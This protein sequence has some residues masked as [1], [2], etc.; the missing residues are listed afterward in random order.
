MIDS[1]QPEFQF[2]RKTVNIKISGPRVGRH[3]KKSIQTNN[4]A[5]QMKNPR[6]NN[7]S[8]PPFGGHHLIK[9]LSIRKRTKKHASEMDR[10][11]HVNAGLKNEKIMWKNSFFLRI[12]E[13]QFTTYQLTRKE[14]KKRMF[15]SVSCYFWTLRRKLF[16]SKHFSSLFV[17]HN[18]RWA[19]KA[20][21]MEHR[22]LVMFG[23]PPSPR[24]KR[25]TSDRHF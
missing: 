18:S 21:Q 19:A 16:H 7:F 24:C 14:W 11:H 20:H 22:C 4:S 25:V 6:K 8:H 5:P 17:H 12:T 2:P 3:G 13:N 9:R 10:H 15:T 23:D 1:V